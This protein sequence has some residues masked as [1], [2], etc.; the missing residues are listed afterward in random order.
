MSSIQNFKQINLFSI[1]LFSLLIFAIFLKLK[2]YFKEQLIKRCYR[3]KIVF[4]N[5]K[6][7]SLFFF[8][9]LLFYEKLL[10]QRNVKVIRSVLLLNLKP[11]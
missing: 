1:V 10:G 5:L 9:F 3:E 8:S 7:K 2:S 6:K 4:P 11:C